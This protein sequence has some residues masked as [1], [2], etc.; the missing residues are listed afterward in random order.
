M[1]RI[2]HSDFR[3]TSQ[4]YHFDERGCKKFIRIFTSLNFIKVQVK[5]QPHKDLHVI[6]RP[7][8]S[9]TPNWMEITF[10]HVEICSDGNPWM[11]TEN[12]INDILNNIWF[13]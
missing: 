7:G 2:S 6:W 5:L 10:P 12:H 4:G 8:I 9:F 13:E 1:L 3:L 11:Y